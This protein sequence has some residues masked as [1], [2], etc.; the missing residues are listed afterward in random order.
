MKTL[1]ICDDPWSFDLHGD[2]TFA[3]MLECAR[4]DSEIWY[5]DS[6]DLSAFGATVKANATQLSVVEGKRPQDAFTIQSKQQIDLSD[7]DW[8]WMRKDPPVDAHYLQA[9]LLLELVTK[10]TNVINAPRSLRDIN[11]HLSVLQFQDICPKTIVTRSKQDIDEFAKECGGKCV[12]KP[13]EGFGGLGVFVYDPTD[14][15]AGSI[16]ELST[17]AGNHWTMAQQFLPQASDGDKRVIVAAG[18][19]VG[20]V[21]R[22]PAKYEARG[23]LHVGGKAVA[24]GVTA[25]DQKIVERVRPFLLSHGI[26]FCGLDIIGGKMTELN[27]TSPTGIRHIDRLTKQNTASMMFDAILAA[28]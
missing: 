21:L 26:W 12:V 13:I 6:F 9:T 17:N 22:V 28:L 14:P 11:E 24:S 5:C 15:N 10:Q 16:L 3:I 2:T 7:M 27:I 19:A 18:N 4:R 1:I 23:N 25:E 8:V 20:A